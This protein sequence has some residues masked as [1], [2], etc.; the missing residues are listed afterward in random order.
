MNDEKKWTGWVWG[1]A[2]LVMWGVGE[3]WG[4]EHLIALVSDPHVSLKA[5]EQSYNR[6]FE[7]VIG[8]VNAAGVEGVV[9]AGDVTQSG[10]AEQMAK[11]AEMVKGFKA[12]V[13]RWVAGNHD[14]GNKV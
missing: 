9:I 13:V 14:V 8:E 6:H 11:F 7:K 2:L 5:E 4:K 10:S 12:P 1:T 3:A